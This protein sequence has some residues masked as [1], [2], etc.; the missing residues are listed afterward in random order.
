[1]CGYLLQGYAF[2]GGGR[3]IVR[4]D[5][6]VDGGATWSTARLQRAAGQEESVGTGRAWAWV[7]WEV[8]LSAAGCWQAAPVACLLY[9]RLQAKALSMQAM[10]EATLWPLEKAFL[11]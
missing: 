7:Q 8:R 3:G 6:S 4:V 11:R 2:S 1:M 10:A 5:V 9:V